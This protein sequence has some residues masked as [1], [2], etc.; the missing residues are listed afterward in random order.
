MQSNKPKTRIY[1]QKP[2][3]WEFMHETANHTVEKQTD[4]ALAERR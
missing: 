2:H 4:D 3:V 1:S